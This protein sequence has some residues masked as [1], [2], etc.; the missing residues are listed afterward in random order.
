MVT[1]RHPS[2]RVTSVAAARPPTVGKRY[3]GV[4]ARLAVAVPWDVTIPPC[5]TA[6]VSVLHAT[7][8]AQL[9]C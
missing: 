1:R 6:K 7:W 9:P 4:N 8:R 3:T 2:Q 5:V